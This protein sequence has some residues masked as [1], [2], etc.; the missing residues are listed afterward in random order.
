MIEILFD[1]SKWCSNVKFSVELAAWY[2]FICIL[3]QVWMVV[4]CAWLRFLGTLQFKLYV[5]EP[6]CVKQNY[7]I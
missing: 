3:V 4:H 2:E 5:S 7:L 6:T 1:F